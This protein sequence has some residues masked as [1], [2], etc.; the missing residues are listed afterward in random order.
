ML[1]TLRKF[2]SSSRQHL[3]AR[4][5][6]KPR[7]EELEPRL[8]PATDIWKDSTGDGL[9]T[10]ANNWSLFRPPDFMHGDVAQ[11]D[12]STGD[13]CTLSPLNGQTS[14]SILGLNLTANYQGKLILNGVGLHMLGT[15]SP[16]STI[17]NTAGIQFTTRQ[18]PN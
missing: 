6:S 4:F 15:T 17:A 16:Q 10:T 8:V 9:W 14:Y 5:V 18:C 2:L 11:F 3:K 12:N 1:R 13:N 7:L